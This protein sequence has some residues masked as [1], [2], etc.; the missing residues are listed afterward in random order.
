[1]PETIPFNY[2]T[3]S[4]DEW[5][6]TARDDVGHEQL[7]WN[8][9]MPSFLSSFVIAQFR[10]AIR[11]HRGIP[12]VI[13]FSP[14]SSTTHRFKAMNV[15]GIE[16]LIIESIHSTSNNHYIVYCCGIEEHA[17]SFD[18]TTIPPNHNAII[19]NYPGKGK[20]I[21]HVR[22]AND[23]YQHALRQVMYLLNKGIPAKNI[24]LCGYSLGGGIAANVARQL[25]EKG[26][27]IHLE[28]TRS[29]DRLSSVMPAL[30]KK[31]HPS[32][33]PFI[34]SIVSLA[35]FGFSLGVAFAG[36]VT[37]LGH[38]L[39][40]SMTAIT[41][42][43]NCIASIIGGI[44]AVVGFVV[45]GLLGAIAG[46]LLSTQLLWTNEPLIPPIHLAFRAILHSFCFEI[47]SVTQLHRLLDS[48]DKPENK[49]QEKPNITVINTLNDEIIP[50]QAAL[51]TGLGFNHE[52]N[53]A[54][55]SLKSVASFW[56]ARGGHSEA[57]ESP[58]HV[59]N[60]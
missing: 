13:H 28:I 33:T 6:V 23:L 17:M 52:K 37:S 27:L 35:V 43:V 55:G 41:E 20:S 38:L 9:I 45:G 32:L 1:M 46:L 57:L 12:E 25:H 5:D 7:Q 30:V 53:Q 26:H 14:P 47:D 16:T 24:T 22:C 10:E 48:H 2:F 42:S 15:D 54:P 34:A 19:W 58:I 8:M 31:M 49:T 40:G 18:V 11:W 36:F 39:A 3:Q 4:I 60:L 59:A 50:V 56:Y 44:I 21:G 29:F 51:N